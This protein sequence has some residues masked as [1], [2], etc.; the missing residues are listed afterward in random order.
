MTKKKLLLFD[1][2]DL[3]KNQYIENLEDYVS[4]EYEIVSIKTDQFVDIV[5]I[6]RNRKKTVNEK[7]DDSNW[8][9][10]FD[11]AAIFIIDYELFK[12]DSKIEWGEDF[13]Y[14]LRYFSKCDYILGLNRFGDKTFDLTLIGHLDSYA[15][16]NI[17]SE[18]LLNRG[19]WTNNF[20]DYRPWYWPTVISYQKSFEK[21]VEDV[22]HNLTKPIH[23]VLK[24]PSNVL[25]A[26]S[27]SAGNQLGVEGKDISTVTFEDFFRKSNI[28][29]KYKDK[30]NHYSEPMISRIIAARI[31][32]W[33]ER[34]ILP[35]QDILVDAPHLVSRYPSLLQG[36]PEDVNS[37]N[38]STNQESFE[39]A[40]INFKLI[41]EFRMKNVHWFSRPVWIWSDVSECKDITEVT[42][43]WKIIESDFVF[44]EDASKFF[45]AKECRQFLPEISSPY[46]RRFIKFFE[47]VT[48]SEKSRLY[49]V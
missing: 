34:S 19:L 44:A 16:L 40:G 14:Y 48:Y 46:T 7:Q 35:G 41:E 15:D 49:K 13:A 4:D 5:E 9:K 22:L 39:E 37:W 3:L 36:E 47:D 10:E 12:A 42:K 18:D 27:N 21:K 17:G 29:L 6:L 2:E 38:A 32:K 1:D 30:D 31:S 33:L 28:V 23:E 43:P 8:N 11:D 20:N 26:I 45:N 24:I 25:I